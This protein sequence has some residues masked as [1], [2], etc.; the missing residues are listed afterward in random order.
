[1]GSFSKIQEDY[2]IILEDFFNTEYREFLEGKNK[3]DITRDAHSR[4]SPVILES[5]KQTLYVDIVEFWKKNDTILSKELSTQGGLN[6]YYETPLGYQQPNLVN[7]IKK[8]GLYSDIIYVSDP[9]CPLLEIQGIRPDWIYWIMINNALELFRCKELT[10]LDDPIMAIVPQNQILDSDTKKTF[11]D[12]IDRYSIDIS[13]KQLGKEFSDMKEVFEYILGANQLDIQTRIESFGNIESVEP[14]PGLVIT[15]EYEQRPSFKTHPVATGNFYKL[16][17]GSQAVGSYLVSTLMNS[18][19]YQANMFCDNR[20]FWEWITEKLRNDNEKLV[21]K[22]GLEI[23]KDSL[24]MNVLN[25]DDFKWLGNVP[26]QYLSAIREEGELQELRDIFRRNI[27]ELNESSHIEYEDISKQIKY[28]LET[29][30]KKHQEDLRALDEKYRKRFSWDVGGIVLGTI[31]G[32]SAFFNPMIGIGMAA[33]G[34]GSIHDLLRN[35]IDK[36][37]DINDIKKKPINILF[38]LKNQV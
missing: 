17:S 5:L 37:D 36:K 8:I 22:Y 2:Y 9:I 15:N 29:S 7:Y 23:S 28:N 16:L 24:I 35:Y 33:L 32:I 20:I 11:V 30:F 10:Q 14:K 27:R 18:S 25:L 12:L 21:E 13:S 3:K 26:V 31:G 19:K 4:F 6:S 38:E 34:G 1:M